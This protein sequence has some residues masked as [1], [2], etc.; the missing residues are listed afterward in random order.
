MI[1]EFNGILLIDKESGITS[2]GVVEQVR[3]I[4]RTKRVGHTG[5][6]DP[7]ATGLLILCVGKATKITRFLSEE[8]KVYR[9]VCHLGVTTDTLDTTGRV[10]ERREVTATDEEITSTFEGVRGKFEQLPPMVSAL[11]H[12]GKPLYEYA[13]AGVE[14]E[15]KPRPVEIFDLAVEG[16]T[17]QDDVQIS[18]TVRCSRGTYIRSLCDDLGER[19]GSG[20]A[21][22]E[23]RRL[24]AGRFRVEDAVTL[25]QL[26]EM[27]TAEVPLM[28]LGEA[29]GDLPALRVNARALRAVANGLPLKPVMVV[30]RLELPAVGEFV[31]VLTAEGKLLAVHEVVNGTATCVT[32]TVR[33]I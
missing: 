3:R 14:I 13:R 4:L 25:E 5:T 31:R 27:D 10:L 29:L 11:K 6:L 1:N 15:R 33:V 17:R 28:E 8:P 32:R 7:Q 24:S 19:L 2:H 20:G 23:L 22:G 30:G 21:M 16:I 26:S 12:Q 9:A 18:F